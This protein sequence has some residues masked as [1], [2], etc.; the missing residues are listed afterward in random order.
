MYT[1]LLLR[2]QAVY[3]NEFLRTLTIVERIGNT[4]TIKGG[5]T[6]FVSKKEEHC[7]PQRRRTSLL[8]KGG[9][10]LCP[11]V[12]VILGAEEHCIPIPS[13]PDIPK[14]EEQCAP[15]YPDIPRAKKH[16]EPA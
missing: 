7:S 2:Y 9:A 13:V 3:K 16:W 10:T 8:L 6:L 12:P 4:V 1:F 5:G 11:S 14:A 15:L